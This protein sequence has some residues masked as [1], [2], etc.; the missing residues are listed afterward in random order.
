MLIL[1]VMAFLFFVVIG[2]AE[3]VAAVILLSILGV[4]GYEL[5]LN[6]VFGWSG[7]LAII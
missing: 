5:C 3:G 6:G 7:F 1:L 4:I 2:S